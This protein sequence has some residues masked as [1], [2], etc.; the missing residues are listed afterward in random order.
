[1]VIA[2]LAPV[3]VISTQIQGLCLGMAAICLLAWV[4][5][6]LLLDSNNEDEKRRRSRYYWY[7]FILLV[8]VTCLFYGLLLIAQWKG[9]PGFYFDDERHYD[10][11][12]PFIVANLQIGAPL[13][14]IGF[15]TNGFNWIIGGIYYLFGY[16][17]ILVRL[18]NAV[19][20]LWLA[21]SVWDIAH[22]LFP[23]SPQIGK[24]TFWLIALN[25]II[26][27]WSTSQ[28]RD[29]QV[30]VGSAL[31]L[32]AVV[33][34]LAQRKLSVIPIGGAGLAWVYYM[35]P[36]SM[37][38]LMV[39]I[40]GGL[41]L[42]ELTRRLGRRMEVRQSGFT[43][44]AV[45]IS[46]AILFT[47]PAWSPT[48]AQNMAHYAS[49]VRLS[50]ESVSGT[51]GEEFYTGEDASTSNYVVSLARTLLVPNPFWIVSVGN[52]NTVVQSIVGIFWYILLPFWFWGWATALWQGSPFL[53][54]IHLF[55]LG[56]ILFS[57]YLP[58]T[59]YADPVR[60]RVPVLAF[61][62][63][64][65]AYGVYLFGNAVRNHPMRH[66]VVGVYLFEGGLGAYYFL[67]RV[68]PLSVFSLQGGLVYGGIFVVTLAIALA[69]KYA[70]RQVFFTLK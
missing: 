10:N 41:V 31:V 28:I 32:W 22:T 53:W 62:M 60:A 27:V 2:A 50:T 23:E 69:A 36:L 42:V 17:P 26:V 18:F 44:G 54:P 13:P 14:I 4:G 6:R 30:A 16:Q 20:G 40:L 8:I 34:L 35:R 65:S 21:A 51:F 67:A 52:F 37:A 3:Y 56:M 38:L 12:A 57:G 45:A 46:L 11:T 43:M 29:I 39:A 48:F 47:Y 9:H 59:E 24:Y 15:Y 68:I 19:G 64:F 70:E 55:T 1:M 25:P 63:L 58:F 61:L 7:A 5:Q 66:F 33:K 49:D